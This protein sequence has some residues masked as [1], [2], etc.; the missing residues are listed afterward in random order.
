MKKEQKR[1]L[2]F[3]THPDDI[4]I[5]CGGTVALLAR[6][7]CEITHVILTSGEAGGDRLPPW[8]VG[9][10]REKEALEAAKILGAANVEF[11]RRP[12]GLTGFS[13]E[14]KLDII[15]VVRRLRPHILF[16][17]ERN[18]TSLGHRVA[19]E[20]VLE[21]LRAGSGPWFQEAGGEPWSPELVLGYEVWHPLGRWELAVD[22]SATLETKIRA[23]ACH[24]S[25]TAAV[26]YDE[27]VRGLARWRGVM[28]LAGGDAE[29]FEVIQ[30]SQ[31]AL[32]CFSR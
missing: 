24:R 29:V 8:E 15:R 5:G 3:G 22:I 1:V 27:A 7:G 13:R 9:P 14:M 25:Q 16:V 30:V 32:S 6:Q 26:R 28:S 17:H 21:A 20:L 11:L 18:E 4:E 31:G 2:A 23:L 10:V 12:D 19:S